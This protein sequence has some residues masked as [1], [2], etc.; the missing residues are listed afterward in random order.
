MIKGTEANI[1]LLYS[2][3]F[4]EEFGVVTSNYYCLRAS[5]SWINLGEQLNSDK[6]SWGHDSLE[7]GT[8]LN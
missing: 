2:D 3:T 1:S 6:K 4:G 5:I 7:K 8:R